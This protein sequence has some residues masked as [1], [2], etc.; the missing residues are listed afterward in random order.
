M[1][2]LKPLILQVLTESCYE[3]FFVKFNF[4]DGKIWFLL[5]L[6]EKHTSWMS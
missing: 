3:E 6:Q 5:E 4:F 1:E 2:Y